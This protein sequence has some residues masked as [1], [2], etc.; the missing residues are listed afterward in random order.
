VS[1]K[2]KTNIT[3]PPLPIYLFLERSEIAAPNI[4][5][6]LPFRD[7]LHKPFSRTNPYPF[8]QSAR[9]NLSRASSNLTRSGTMSSTES[10]T[11][12]T[13]PDVDDVRVTT[14][15][16]NRELGEWV[17]NKVSGESRDRG[18]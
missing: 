16:A 10:P 2:G 4:F 11:D 17:T 9:G 1:L 3:L 7:P 12:G 6:V 5:E 18:I 15:L 8:D 14:Y 13:T